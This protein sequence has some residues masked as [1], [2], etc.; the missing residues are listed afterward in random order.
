MLNS[1]S[2]FRILFG[3]IGALSLQ[4][5]CKCQCLKLKKNDLQRTVYK[6]YEPE[7]LVLTLQ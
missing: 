7:L 4:L 5:Q 3:H 1:E 2:T 6:L